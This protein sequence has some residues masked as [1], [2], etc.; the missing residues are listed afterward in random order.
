[1][2]LGL[3][4]TWEEQQKVFKKKDF[5]ISQNRYLKHAFASHTHMH[6]EK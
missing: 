3:E 4:E 1:M 2:A 6:T 5:E